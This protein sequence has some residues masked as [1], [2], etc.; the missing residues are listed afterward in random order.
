[1]CQSLIQQLVSYDGW[2][3]RYSASRMNGIYIQP[4]GI[5]VKFEGRYVKYFTRCHI[6]APVCVNCSFQF[7]E[8]S[9]EPKQIIY[10]NLITNLIKLL[11]VRHFPRVYQKIN[12]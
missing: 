8:I 1:M 10:Q 3:T 11:N 2:L 9:T 5:N 12:I 6:K 4:S 7:P